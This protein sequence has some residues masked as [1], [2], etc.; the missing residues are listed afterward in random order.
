MPTR[1]RDRSSTTLHCRR[2]VPSASV[3]CAP[4]PVAG[5]IQPSADDIGDRAGHRDAVDLRGH[6]HRVRR[7]PVDE[8]HRAV[9]GVQDPGDGA[10][11]EARRV[12][13]AADFL[14]ENGVAGSQLRQPITQQPL[15]FGVDDGHRVSRGRLGPHR[16]IAV[17][18]RVGAEYLA[19]ASTH[20]RGRLGGQRLGHRPQRCRLVL[21]CAHGP[22]ASQV[23]PG[24]ATSG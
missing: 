23:S 3:T 1:A 15:G 19:A 20:E 14:A 22:I 5:G 11:R 9:D 13:R 8:V 24:S 6:R 2:R 12:G 4:S 17:G 10:G 18:A 16:V 7:D 21:R